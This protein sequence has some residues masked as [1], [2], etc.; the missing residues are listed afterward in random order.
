MQV[1]SGRIVFATFYTKRSNPEEVHFLI[2][3]RV[4]ATFLAISSKH[5]VLDKIHRSSLAR[6]KAANT[7]VLF[8][9]SY[10]YPVR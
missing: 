8:P 1:A 5:C 3:G 2:P 6:L 4:G 9:L 7:H 10:A